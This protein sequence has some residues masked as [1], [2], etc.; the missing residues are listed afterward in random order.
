MEYSYISQ[1]AQIAQVENE[2][3]TDSLSTVT[4]MA[5]I[6]NLKASLDELEKVIG[7]KNDIINKSENESVKRNAVI[8]RKQ[9]VIDQF[10]KRLE[11]MISQ[12][13]VGVILHCTIHSMLSSIACVFYYLVSSRSPF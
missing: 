6:T 10:N 2:I 8:E 1:E 13:G 11:Q 3:A 4:T 9:Q 7:Q 5:K 12:A